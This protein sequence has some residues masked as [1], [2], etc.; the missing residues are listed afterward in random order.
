MFFSKSTRGFY[1]AEIHCENI[2]VDAVEI[3][4]EDH[5]AI[6]S[7][8]SSGK[9]ISSNAEGFPVLVDPPGPTA[10]QAA[11]QY[12]AAAQCVL[13]DLAWSWGYGDAAGKG[14]ADRLVSYVG[15]PEPQF[16]ADAIAFRA[17]RSEFWKAAAAIKVSVSK[18][19]A[20]K[21][22]TVDEF[23]A[24]LPTPPAKPVL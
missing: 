22:S 19:D 12:T 14:C 15:D 10:D 4:A 16:N 5:S 17:W 7:G 11:A 3:T 6:L 2:P 20:P 8:Q 21:P 24:L 23:L 1:D 9:V 13:D 18:A